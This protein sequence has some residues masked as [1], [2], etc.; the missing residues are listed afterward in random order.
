MCRFLAYFSLNADNVNTTH[1]CKVGPGTTMQELIFNTSNS[2]VEQSKHAKMRYEPTNGDGFGVGWYPM[3]DDNEPGTF[4]SIEPAWNN[5]N[6]LQLASKVNTCQFFAHIRDASLGMPVSQANC[7][8]FQNG[9]YLWMHNG[10]LHQ[11]ELIRR[12]LL[13]SLSDRAFEYV[14]GNTDSEHAFALFLDHISFNPDPTVLEIETAMINTLQE[15]IHLRQHANLETDADMNFAVS[16]GDTA[17][18]TRF[19][20][21]IEQEP[22]SLYYLETDKEIIIASEPLTEDSHWIMVE[23]NHMLTVQSSGS[24]EI[25]AISLT[26]NE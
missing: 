12:A 2:L 19:T 11:F 13:N 17:V 21:N 24:L 6:L 10:H 7:H 15:I 4:V 25:K 14:D 8:P 1:G 18:F 26:E 22:P 5:R 3:H 9:R 16:N 20:F 23:R